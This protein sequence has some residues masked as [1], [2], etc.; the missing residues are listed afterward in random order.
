MAKFL[1]LAWNIS[2]WINLREIAA[3]PIINVLNKML[4]ILHHAC[5]RG[6]NWQCVLLGGV[7][8]GLRFYF[9]DVLNRVNVPRS[10]FRKKVHS[11]IY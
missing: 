2:E 10:P 11:I 6:I 3:A 5:M 9:L 7:T 1:R 8:Q 4:N